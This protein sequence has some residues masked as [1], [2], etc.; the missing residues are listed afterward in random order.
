MN[1]ALILL[2]AC[3]APPAF[4]Q[5]SLYVVNG[6]V[7]QPAPAALDLGQVYPTEPAA[8]QF[9]IRNTSGAP[10]PLSLLAVN[11]A[12]FALSGAPALPA[13]LNPQQAIDFTVVFQAGIPGGYSAS[14]DTEGASVLLTAT[15]L[16]RLT[17]QVVVPAGA[18]TL[19]SSPIDFGAAVV[20]TSSLLHFTIA[21]L[22]ALVLAAPG[23]AVQGGAFSLP[24]PTPAGLVFQPGDTAGFDVVFAPAAV[25]AAS[26]ALVIGDRTYALAGTGLPLPLPNPLLAIALPQARSNQQGTVAVNLDAAAQ[27]AGT[28][29]LALAFQPLAPGAGDPA[30]QLGT[31]GLALGF[32]FAA[33]DTQGN[34]S[35]LTAVNFQTGTTAGTLAFTAAI[36]AS[37]AQQ[38]IVIPPA[39][40]GI[41]SAAGQRGTGSITLNVAGFDNTRTAG[42]ATYAF[43]DGAGNAI[44]PAIRVD[45]TAAFAAYFAAS[46][47]GGNFLLQAVFPVTGNVS[48]IAAFEVQLANSAGTATTGQVKF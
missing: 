8:A 45:S 16:P 26:G 28:G 11:G 46:S 40:V 36:G 29:T 17:Y 21:N 12:G 5:F 22:T 13:G 30:I 47:N 4:A 43:Y 31:V 10:A 9:R 20:G 2:A 18:Q 34:F 44:G 1:R 15:V 23:I 25:G 19:G 48:E 39:P 27:S 14:L 35:G 32:S 33:G 38:S 24:G 41:L 7:E 37:S 3:L 6:N 42:V